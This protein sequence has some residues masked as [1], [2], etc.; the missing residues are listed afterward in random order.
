[1]ATNYLDTPILFIVFNRPDLTAAV[2]ETIRNVKPSRLYISADGPRHGCERDFL[3]TAQVRNIVTKV[4]WPCQLHT[5][6]FSQNNG[7][8]D[9]EALAMGWFF[10]HEPEGI[11]LEDDTL[12]SPTF[13]PYCQSLLAKYRDCDRVFSISG[14]SYLPLSPLEDS[15]Y[16]FSSYADYWGWAGWRRSWDTYDRYIKDFPSWRDCDGLAEIFPF[17]YEARKYW[18]R[19]LEMTYSGVVDT[20]D[21]QMLFNMWSH[22]ALS[23]MPKLNLVRNLGFRADGTHTTTARQPL[24]LRNAVYSDLDGLIIHPETIALDHAFDDAFFRQIFSSSAHPLS[25]KSL[26]RIISSWLRTSRS[27]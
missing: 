15:S 25:L 26:L 20:W 5:Q 9:G 24:W 17:N 6:F 12:P 10:S 18:Y 23:V 3:L 21:Y 2:F 16:F 22:R 14:N 13:F 11:I 4:D 19:L 27:K 7:C 8:R 1:M